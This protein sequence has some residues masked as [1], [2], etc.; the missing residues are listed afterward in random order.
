MITLKN[1][2]NSPYS[3]TMADGKK[4]MLPARGEL[5]DVDPSPVDLQQLRL[6]GYITI[7]EAQ[8]EPKRLPEPDTS[9]ETLQYRKPRNKK[10][11]G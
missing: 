11:G 6:C 3:I 4:E 7:E 1:Q 8:A 10:R 5:V 2:T 9:R